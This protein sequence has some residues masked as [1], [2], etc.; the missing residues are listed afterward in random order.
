VLL[1]QHPEL[2]GRLKFLAFLVPSRTGVPEY[3]RYRD[4]VFRL[5]DRINARYGDGS[6]RPIELFY[7][8]NF[9][10]ALAGMTLYDVLL[11]N[12]LADGMNLVAK[13]GPAVNRRDGVLVLST[14]A[15]AFEELRDGA[16]AVMPKDVKGTAGALWQAL[17]MPLSERRRRA[18]LLRA[19]ITER[20]LTAWMREQLEELHEVAV[21]AAAEPALAR[22][23][24]SVWR[25]A[26]A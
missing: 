6:W 8:N 7:E 16:L 9:Q 24:P 17:E 21:G 20:D 2:R 14:G 3:R 15:G 26:V 4:R 5:I 22:V 10:Q 12:S 25:T 19:V 13:E 23:V 18:H 1:R 11:V